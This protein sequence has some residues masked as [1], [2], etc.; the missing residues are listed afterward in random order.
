[1]E[2]NEK[3]DEKQEE[4]KENF[5]EKIIKLSEEAIESLVEDGI[6]PSDLE[7]LDKLV[8]IHKDICEEKYWKRKENMYMNYGNYGNY[9]NYNGN[10]GGQYGNYG[11]E[12]YG[13]GSYGRDSYGRRGYD[14]KYRGDEHLDRMHGEY[15]RYSENRERY[16]ANQETDKSFYYMVEALK[17]FIKVLYE[18]ADTQQQKQQLKQTLQNSMM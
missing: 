11:R 14:R 17:D 3:K 1:M 2:E 12:Q 9:G 8:D 16:G 15:N 10:Y 4:I 6:Q 5:Y 7:M 13:D 18:E